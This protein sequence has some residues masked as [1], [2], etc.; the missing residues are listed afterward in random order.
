MSVT[1]REVT[2][3]EAKG[4]DAT[5]STADLPWPSMSVGDRLEIFRRLRHAIADDPLD[6]ARTVRP[7]Q[8]RTLAESV[9]AEVWALADACQ[10]LEKYA[11]RILAPTVPPGG[12]WRDWLTGLRVRIH[13]Q[14]RGKV[15]VIGAG[16]YPLLLSAVPA[17]QALVAGNRVLLKPPLGGEACCKMF[18]ETLCKAGLPAGTCELL[19]ATAEAAK[20][21]IETGVD[22]VVFTGS[23]KVGQ[24]VWRQA[25]AAGATCTLELSGCD[26]VVVLAGADPTRV[27]QCLAFGLDFNAS[28]TCIAPRRVFA[29]AAMMAKI[30]ERLVRLL[31]QCETKICYAGAANRAMGSVQQALADGAKL[32]WPNLV[33]EF[34]AGSQAMPPMVL[35]TD[36]RKLAILDDDLFAPALTLVT[37]EGDEQAVAAANE[38]RWG[39]GAA[40][41]GPRHRAEQVATIMEAGCVTVNDLIAPTAD[42][43]VPFGGWKQS[44]HGMTRGREGLL[45]MTKAQAIIARTGMWLPHLD[46]KRS[47]LAELIAGMVTFL[48]GHSIAKRWNGL[49][50]ITRATKQ[51]ESTEIK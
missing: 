5:K 35:A 10:F 44:G 29:S 20:S 1:A 36:N 17:L 50:E 19:D 32:V 47:G 46:R 51:T 28:A 37:V 7:T 26:A 45:E 24:Q 11:A 33:S 48:H 27:A 39:L 14:P 8:D 21:A 6:W 43:R 2:A 12:R 49:S 18:V 42:A 38:S 4:I 30:E 23:S 3:T 34:G 15:L 40:V 16:N 9:G 31:D 25:T 41:F 13:H 22:H